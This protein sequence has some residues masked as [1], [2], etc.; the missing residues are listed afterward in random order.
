MNANEFSLFA[1][2]TL[3]MAFP[4]Y[5]VRL[6][7]DPDD[8]AT[9]FAYVFC[10]PDGA[11]QKVKASVRAEIHEHLAD[12]GWDVIPAIKNLTTTRRYYP[13]YLRPCPTEQEV[14]NARVFQVV[15][16]WSVDSDLNFNAEDDVFDL[17]DGGCSTVDYIPDDVNPHESQFKIAA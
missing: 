12:T 15:E 5:E 3:A 8:A 10:V 11:E 16:G 13:E 9:F 7:A 2:N 14:S 17:D 6:F 1:Q 4:E